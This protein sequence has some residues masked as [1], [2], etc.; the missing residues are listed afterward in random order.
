MRKVEDLR[1]RLVH[2]RNKVDERKRREK[3]ERMRKL[4][5]ASTAALALADSSEF[6]PG[7]F[8]HLSPSHTRA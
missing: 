7:A 1:V 2:A 4:R 3:E 5:T 8:A 6:P